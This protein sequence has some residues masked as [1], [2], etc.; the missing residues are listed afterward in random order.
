MLTYFEA[1]KKFQDFKPNAD[2]LAIYDFVDF[3]VI[4]FDIDNQQLLDAFY[5]VDKK[6]GR[7]YEYN[8]LLDLKIWKRVVKNPVYVK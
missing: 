3:F 2:I 7:I 5:A 4:S 1:A 6:S 8:P